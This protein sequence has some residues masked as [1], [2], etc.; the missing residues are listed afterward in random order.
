MRRRH[1]ADGDYQSS[2]EEVRSTK[3]RSCIAVSPCHSS[4]LLSSHALRASI[5][6]KMASVCAGGRKSSGPTTPTP[7]HSSSTSSSSIF[8]ARSG[9]SSSDSLLTSR[10]GVRE[11]E[12]PAEEPEE[13][14]RQRIACLWSYLS[15][16]RR[17]SD[18]GGCR[19]RLV[20]F[21]AVLYNTPLSLG[22]IAI[23]GSA[24]GAPHPMPHGGLWR[25]I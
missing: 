20:Y 13:S 9:G 17:R 18:G 10:S 3:I 12:A 23:V 19:P 6:S 2:L 11:L 8:T 25:R 16:S 5:A 22:V 14:P 15:I 24:V 21:F 7:R 1:C 4:F